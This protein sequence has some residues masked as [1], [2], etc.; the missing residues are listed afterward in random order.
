[1]G[2]AVV[3][4]LEVLAELPGLAWFP[5]WWGSLG[6][7]IGFCALGWRRRDRGWPPEPHD[8]LVV[9]TLALLAP[10]ATGLAVL[11]P[12]GPG[13]FESFLLYFSLALADLLSSVL[14]LLA[15]AL[16]PRWRA[17]RWTVLARGLAATTG[18]F[19]AAA[20][21]RWVLASPMTT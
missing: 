8:S 16:R 10:A 19:G 13:A 2:D 3:A 5:L 14:A 7:A 9:T 21:V 11:L 4:G 6:L 12:S 17:A 18:L 1:M 15:L 20:C